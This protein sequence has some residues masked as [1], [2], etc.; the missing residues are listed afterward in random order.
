MGWGGGTEI[1]DTVINSMK[2]VDIDID[3]QKVIVKQLLDVLEE[4]DYDNVCESKYYSTIE[5][6]E[7]L[8]FDEEESE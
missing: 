3:I 4:Q 5:Y 6:G 7:V 8:G 1:L 2:S